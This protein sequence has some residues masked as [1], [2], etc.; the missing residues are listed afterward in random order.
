MTLYKPR[1]V[2]TRE[3]GIPFSIEGINSAEEKK[4]KKNTMA[5]LENYL[6]LFSFKPPSIITGTHYYK[7]NAWSIYPLF[8]P[9]VSD[10]PF[11][12]VVPLFRLLLGHGF[13]F[14]W[15]LYVSS[16]IMMLELGTSFPYQV[17]SSFFFSFVNR[18]DG[19]GWAYFL[20][21]CRHFIMGPR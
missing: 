1:G 17:V 13:S 19:S 16:L 21:L 14:W 4:N 9:S 18:H 6:P 15:L 2:W 3:I 10:N 12:E 8:S 7:R 11:E 5:D 20:I